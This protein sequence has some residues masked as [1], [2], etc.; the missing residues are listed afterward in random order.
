MTNNPYSLA[1]SQYL[2]DLARATLTAVC[3]SQNLPSIDFQ[4]LPEHLIAKRACF[5][6]LQTL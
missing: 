5:V 2:L 1:E 3:Q 6:T 4:S